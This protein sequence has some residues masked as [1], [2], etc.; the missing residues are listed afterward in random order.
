MDWQNGRH[1]SS[2]RGQSAAGSD[3]I[4]CWI[5]RRH[6]HTFYFSLEILTSF[7]GFLPNH[8]KCTE[9]FYGVSSENR[10]FP[11][12]CWPKQNI[13]IHPQKNKRWWTETSVLKICSNQS[14]ENISR[15]WSRWHVNGEI[16]FFCFWTTVCCSPLV[17][18]DVC[19]EFNVD[20]RY[21]YR[22]L[23]NSIIL[24]STLPIPELFR[25]A[26]QKFV[27]LEEYMVT[28]GWNSGTRRCNM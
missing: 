17:R 28:L 10:L 15:V 14:L 25:W 16:A 27:N 23:P 5:K 3:A 18:V 26:F 11:K 7:Y 21:V 2:A 9:H 19:W 22:L 8:L 20:Y 13:Y 6:F 24:L 4:Q 12:T 1:A